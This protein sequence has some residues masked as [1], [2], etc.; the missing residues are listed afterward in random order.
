MFVISECPN[1]LRI[2][3][4]MYK[5]IFISYFHYPNNNN[6]GKMYQS[7]YIYYTIGKRKPTYTAYIYILN[8]NIASSQYLKSK[9]KMKAWC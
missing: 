9:S 8:K 3:I 7:I 2:K 4:Y 5:G 1:N 6:R